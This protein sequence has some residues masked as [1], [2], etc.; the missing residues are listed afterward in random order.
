[1]KGVAGV[2]CV[3]VLALLTFGFVMLASTSSASAYHGD[4]FYYAK[5]QA[6]WLGLGLVG[7]AV[8]ACVD[9]RRYRKLAWPLFVLA[10]VLLAGVLILGK[11]INGATRWFSYGAFRF[12]PSEF[13]KYALLLV[14]ALWLEQ[15]QRPTKGQPQPRIGHWWWGVFAPIGITCVPAV[16]ILRENDLG[17][18]LLLGAMALL[19]MWVGG[20]PSRWLA[21]ILAAGGAGAAAGLVAILKFGMFQRFYQVQR[22]LHWWRWDDL[23]GSNYQQWMAMLAFGSGG[24]LGVGL[25]DSRMKMANL[26]EAHTDFIFP[27]IGEELGLVATLAV[28]AAFVVIIVCGILL[29][30]HSPDLFGLL[31][32][33]GIIALIGLQAIINIAV[34][35]NTVPNKGM[36]LPFISYGGSNLVMTLA[37]LGVLLNIFSRAHAEA[38][39]TLTEPSNESTPPGGAFRQSSWGSGAYLRLVQHGGGRFGH[40]AWSL[41]PRSGSA[42][43]GRK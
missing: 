12:Q 43:E 38:A 29:A 31:L 35:T 2:F 30:T 26:P 36:P 10:V 33:S 5:R 14:L 4:P 11:R 32:G 19:A 28:V 40:R 42:R 21:A 27:I 8:T 16:L 9:Y 3:T 23:Q 13:A 34:V 18:T 39:G 24:P 37:A 20:A 1:M 17:T 7:C 41:A 6:V 25:G 15:M 22:F